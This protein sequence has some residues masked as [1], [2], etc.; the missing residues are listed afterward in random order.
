MVI[1]A[2]EPIPRQPAP[3]D[4]TKDEAAV[5]NAVVASQPA[6]WFNGS[7][8]P[9]LKQYSRHC[10]KADHIAGLIQALEASVADAMDAPGADQMTI[11]LSAA[12]A[13]DKLLKMQERE[14][15][16]MTSIATKMRI[17]Q[18]ATTNHRGNKIE[19]KKPWEYR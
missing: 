17:T 14:S 3:S 10:V 4:L 5:W 15:R 16:A 8:R 1:G 19:S 7:T 11:M 2:V 18:Q 12:G 9:L 13:L 6:D